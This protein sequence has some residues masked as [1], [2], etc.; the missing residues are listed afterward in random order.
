MRKYVDVAKPA[1]VH[2]KES[3]DADGRNRLVFYAEGTNKSKRKRARERERERTRKKGEKRYTFIR[4]I[5]ICSNTFGVKIADN[6][7]D[8][9][10][11]GQ[12]S[13]R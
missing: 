13:T 5:C 7:R 10:D 9:D 3:S 2:T 1:R 8:T 4:I 12:S 6:G 11:Q